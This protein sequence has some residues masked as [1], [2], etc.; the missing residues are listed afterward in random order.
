MNRRKVLANLAAG[1]A[2]IPSL[3]LG[4]PGQTAHRHKPDEPARDCEPPRRGPYA[5][6]FPNVVVQT[7]EGRKA[8]FYDDLLR[9][10]TVM[11]NC[12]SVANDSVYPVTANLVKVQRLLGERAGRDVFIY[13]ITV[14]P[15]R[16]TPRVLSAFAEKHEVG[17]GWLFLTGKPDDLH[18]LRGRLF[19]HG[20][21]HGAHGKHKSDPVQDCSMGVVRYGNVAVGLWG[22]F[23]AKTEAEWVL[24][25]LSWVESRPFPVGPP[26][27]KVQTSSAAATS[28]SKKATK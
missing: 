21:G 20:G 9:G 2:A 5:D 19:A 15:E 24:K 22:A 10:K 11:I 14:E 1:A 25:R 18:A 4:T 6:Y 26:R 28:L 8:L 3:A 23:P 16:D 12:M 17:P 7:H 13:S 27:R